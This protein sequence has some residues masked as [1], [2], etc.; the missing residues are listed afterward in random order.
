MEVLSFS[1][2]E[3]FRDLTAPLLLQAEASHSLLI[4]ITSNLIDAPGMYPEFHLWCVMDER[5]PVLAALVTPPWS[6]VLSQASD[7]SAV[8]TLALHL[9]ND[10][11]S[12]TGL[13]ALEPT[14]EVFASVWAE[15][16][17]VHAE[18][19]MSQGIFQ[20]DR[21]NHRGTAAGEH[22]V[23]TPADQDLVM[24]WA[25]GF[26]RDA[27]GDE[28]EA[29]PDIELFV[30]RLR[31]DPELS[32]IWLWEKGGR[33]VSMSM[34]ARPTPTGMTITAVYTPPEHRGNGYATSLVA[35][36]SQWLLDS[37]RD[38][39]FLYTD[40]SNPTSNAIYKRIGYRQVAE[41]SEYSFTPR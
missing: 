14:G 30:R 41:S 32:S 2:P 17:D 1:D 40:L 39:C 27:A 20:L 16:N 26:M 9:T 37:G 24:G 11:V 6:L 22:R 10:R 28:S 5:T 25:R 36:Q 34:Y 35:A 18:R 21:V 13:V 8:A 12:L 7:P 38:K 31:E 3:E 4:G 19:D 33:P 23:A 15:A 29:G